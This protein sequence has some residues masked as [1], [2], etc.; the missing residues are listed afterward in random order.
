MIN[1]DLS[2]ELWRMLETRADRDRS[3]TLGFTTDMHGTEVRLETFSV[4][5]MLQGGRRE[6]KRDYYRMVRIATGTVLYDQLEGVSPKFVGKMSGD[7]FLVPD[8]SI[9]PNRAN[10]LLRA[11]LEQQDEVDRL[12]AEVKT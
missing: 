12:I 5:K 6:K 3:H 7:T 2:N 11:A 4:W 1:P 10:K 9:S 8:I